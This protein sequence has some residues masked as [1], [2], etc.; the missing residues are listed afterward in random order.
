MASK[1]KRPT[2]AQLRALAILRDHGPMMPKRFAERMWPDSPSW[3]KVVRCGAHGSHRGGGM[4]GAAGGFLGKLVRA[5]LV[6]RTTR[7]SY[8]YNDYEL[9]PAGRAALQEQPNE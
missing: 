8:D 6:R 2:A 3:K 5:G 9:S 1:T 4:Y 7:R